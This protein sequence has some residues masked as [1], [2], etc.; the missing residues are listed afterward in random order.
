MANCEHRQDQSKVRHARTRPEKK[1]LP[2]RVTHFADVSRYLP[3]AGSL[4]TRCLVMTRQSSRAHGLGVRC[5][6]STTRVAPEEFDATPIFKRACLR[7]GGSRG[8]TAGHRLR[9][10]FHL[11]ELWAELQQQQVD[12]GGLEL[13][14]AFGHLFRRTH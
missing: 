13:R 10:T 6:R 11:L 9:K 8:L 14:T 2:R 12:P 5:G 7:Q 1:L 4:W 3:A